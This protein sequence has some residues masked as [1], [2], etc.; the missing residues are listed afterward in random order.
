MR[1]PPSVSVDLHA[2]A[3]DY[4]D[5]RLRQCLFDTYVGIPLI[6]FPEDLRTYEHLLWSENV[7]V[8]LEL[9]VESGGSTLWFRDRLRVLASYGR[10]RTPRVIGVDLDI[11][12]AHAHLSEIDPGYQDQILLIEGDLLDP[13]LAERVRD[14]IPHGTSCLVIEDSAHT[15]ETTLGA[16]RGFASL[17]KPGGFFVVEDGSVDI[18]EMRLDPDW[19]RGVLAAIQ[20]WLSTPEGRCFMQRRDLELYGVS[21]HPGGFLQRR[22]TESGQP[23]DPL[24]ASPLPSGPPSPNGRRSETLSERALREQL[25]DTRE[26]LRRT[27]A[28]LVAAREFEQR[29]ERVTGSTSWRL[30]RPLRELGLRLRALLSGR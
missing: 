15:H 19:P 20:E 6:K 13:A 4:F 18:E 9:G 7:E 8:V 14:L 5:R 23:V 16:L 10:I 29:F 28:E 3:L 30:T 11:S 27:E 21:C 26:R 1:L 2:P 25:T 22:L 17:V 24:A 12:K